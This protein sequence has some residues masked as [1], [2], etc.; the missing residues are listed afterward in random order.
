V[1]W[2]KGVK[3]KNEVRSQWHHVVDV[4]QTVLEAAGLPEPRSVNGTE[5]I[6]M[7]GVSMLY[8]FDDAR[9]PGRHLTQYFEIV[10]NRGIYHDGW[11]AG[12]VHKAPW[13][14][15]P[16]TSLAADKWELYDTRADFS[17]VN[18]LAQTNPAKLKEMQDLFTKVAIENHVLPIDDRSIERLNAAVAGRPDL[19]GGRTSLTVY[20]G[21]SNLMENAF[22]NVKNRSFSIAADVRIPASGASGVA[23]AQGGRFGGWSLWLKDGRPRFTYN[24]LGIE[25]YEVA[26]GAPLQAGEQVLR[27]DFAYDGGKPGA[28][29]VG[30]LSVGGTTLAEGR[31]DR[32]QPFAFSADE[33]ADVGE[34]LATPVSEEYQAPATFTG[35]IR[36]IT[37]EVQPVLAA[38]RSA[39]DEAA[40]QGLERQAEFE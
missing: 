10:G 32:T 26:A 39:V 30:R 33:G 15:Q 24:W 9:A 18:D 40:I 1:H 6:P 16:R 21:M 34:D 13:E 17:L 11:L 28:G 22:I 38:D 14:L 3:A 5:Q 27:F 23:L 4:A 12:T 19:M 7:Q 29:G 25:R 20:P 8:S 31:I 36:K 2:P 37:I 35:T